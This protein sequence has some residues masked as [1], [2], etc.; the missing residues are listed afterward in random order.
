[1]MWQDAVNGVFEFMGAPMVLM[2]IIKLHRDKK[3]RGVSLFPVV[4][5]SSWGYWNLYYY[6]HLNQV[7][8]W[9]GGMCLVVMNTVWM[10]QLFY[11][12]RKEKRMAP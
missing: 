6:S 10:V 2:S 7:C 5:F 8:S 12:I 11:Y 3:V 1:M 4:F 9:I